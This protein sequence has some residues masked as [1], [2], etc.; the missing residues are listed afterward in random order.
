MPVKR[1]YC[2]C[3]IKNIRSSKFTKKCFVPMIHILSDKA[4]LLRADVVTSIDKWSDAIG[5]ENVINQLVLEITTGNPEYRDES[6][7]WMTA[8]KDAIPKCDHSVMIKPLITAL[9]DKKGEI[10]T[11]S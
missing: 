4:A 7:K 3:P 8:H 10:R 2:T 9:T 1:F 6:L 5:P 11:M